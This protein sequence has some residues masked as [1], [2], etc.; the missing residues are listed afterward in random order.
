MSEK[1]TITND[2]KT[3]NDETPIMFTAL[4]GTNI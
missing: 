3:E 4:V 2:N 1:I